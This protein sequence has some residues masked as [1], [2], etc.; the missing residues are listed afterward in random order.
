[1]VGMLQKVC[2]LLAKYLE[3]AKGS[4]LYNNKLYEDLTFSEKQEDEDCRG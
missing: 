1:M 2:K 3:I 4:L